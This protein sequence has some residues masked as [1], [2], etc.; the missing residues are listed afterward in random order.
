[1]S[2]QFTHVHFFVC[3]LMT[4]RNLRAHCSTVALCCIAITW[5]RIFKGSFQV[6]IVNAFSA[7]WLLTSDQCRMRQRG[8]CSMLTVRG[9]KLKI[10]LNKWTTVKAYGL[11]ASMWVPLSILNFV[12]TEKLVL[13]ATFGNYMLHNFCTKNVN[14]C[15]FTKKEYITIQLTST[16]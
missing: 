4:M 13:L 12:V 14:A 8:V 5:Q 9:P 2:L 11:S 1:M 15:L 7:M 3:R 10:H 6:T 16:V